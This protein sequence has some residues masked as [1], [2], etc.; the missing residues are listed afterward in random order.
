MRRQFAPFLILAAACGDSPSPA[1]QAPALTDSAIGQLPVLAVEPGALVC[2]SIGA[3][4]CPLRGAVANRLE[5]GR[6][7]LWEPGFTIYLFGA[8]DTLGTPVGLAGPAGQYNY[9]VAATAVG[10]DRYRLILADQPWRAIDINSAG[11]ISRVD[12]LPDPGIL[13][14]VG[15]IGMRLVR[16]RMSG[17]LDDSGGTFTV[18]LLDRTT[19]S[20]G[21]VV[22]ET[23][24]PWL[25]GGNQNGPPVP[26]LIAS[27]PSWTLTD[28]GDLVWSPGDRLSI[29]RR[30]PSGRVRWHLDGDPGPPV[31]VEDLTAR[32]SLM[33]VAT[34]LMPYSDEHFAEMRARA[35]SLHPA[36]TGVIVTPVGDVLVARTVFPTR[37]SVEYLRISADGQPL[38]RFALDRRI[39]ILLADGDSLLTHTPTEGEPWEVRW[40]R[41]LMR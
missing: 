21:R 16:Q 28:D 12:T 33:R 29:E 7:A 1:S 30:S 3:D 14:A 37:D 31:S 4:G 13:T 17:W 27:S 41:V 35:D 39:R 38:G 40:M 6:I 25:H 9:A 22:L 34:D 2:T 19:D 10:R 5:D 11:E 36:V 32:D 20:T 26:P 24:L 8:G 15:Y 23:P 18:T